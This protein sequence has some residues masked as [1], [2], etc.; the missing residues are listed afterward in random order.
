MIG[1]TLSHYRVLKQLGAG[2]MGVVY[3]ARDTRLERDVAIKMLPKEFA[4]DSE[5]L[6]RFKREAKVL[7][8]LNHSNIGAIYGLEEPKRGVVFLVLEWI[9]GETL[10]ARLR[11]GPLPPGEALAVCAH[12]AGALAA[13]HERGVIHRDLKPANVMLTASGHAK[14]LDFGLARRVAVRTTASTTT[15]VTKPGVAMGTLGYASPEQVRGEEHDG[16]AD[17]FAL[18]CVL[19]ECLT[20]K[21]AFSGGTAADVLA[22]TL[23]QEPDWPALP[24]ETPIKI[25]ELLE[26]CLRKEPQE[27]LRSM[28]DARIEID[29]L[30]GTR[31]LGG[32]TRAATPAVPNN[33]PKQLTNFVGREAEIAECRG[34]LEACRLLTLTGTGGC[35]KTRLSLHVVGELLDQ[36]PDGLW[37][38]DLAPLFDGSRVPQA[39]ASV[40]NV[41]ERSDK[42]LS[43]TLADHLRDRRALLLLDNCE[44]MRQ[45]SAELAQVLL[46][47]CPELKLIATSREALGVPGER[48]YAVPPLSL[49]NRGEELEAAALGSY[50][51]IRLFVD[52]ASLVRSGF[53]LTDSNARAVAEICR[54]LDGIPLAIE[55]AAAR[56]KVLSPA[57][58]Q[59]KLDDRFRLLTGGSAVG[60]PRHQTLEA[61]VRWSYDQLTHDEQRLFRAVSVFSGGW[62]LE[63]AA[64]VIND[65][66]DE[67]AVLDLLT[68]LVD[69]SLVTVEGY[70]GGASRY[71]FLETIRE[72]AVAKLKE[73]GEEGA[74]RGRHL[75]FFLSLAE[76]AGPHLIEEEEEANWLLR[77]ER[78][79]ENLLT[80]LTWCE[81]AED[82]GEKALRLA[83]AIGQFWHTR[84]HVGLG[85]KILGRALE[86]EG[87]AA[88]TVARAKALSL[89]ASLTFTQGDY[90][91]A[92]AL[93]EASFTIYREL[94]D[95]SGIA[96]GLQGRAGEAIM[97]GDLGTARLVLEESLT[98]SREA[99]Y[100][101]GAL[102]GLLGLG[103]VARLG[104]DLHLARRWFEESL[105]LSRKT[106]AKRWIVNNLINLADLSVKLGEP[107]KGRA[108]LVEAFHL[109]QELGARHAATG[110]LES[111]AWVAAACGHPSPAA[112]F[113]GAAEVLRQTMG[114]PLHGPQTDL[115]ERDVVQRLVCSQLGE[116]RFAAGVA[117]GR[118]QS[119]EA[120]IADAL[121]W[122]DQVEPDPGAN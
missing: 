87:A 26:R 116:A 96:R 58:I 61:T 88:G 37:V 8:S 74:L 19:Y 54:R 15:F 55:L 72:Y 106:H 103:V 68:R 122:I 91:R 85:R 27:R 71:G 4:R 62:G 94:G 115:E 65:S 81:R 110:A 50:E 83:G 59:A 119:F 108:R 46:R 89:L 98:I 47:E 79:H 56:A 76:T 67:I 100:E 60:L 105:A 11:R 66:A 20:G 1:R 112:R 17:I 9:D 73:S 7:A 5:R 41:R 45:S 49:P 84:G 114:I 99:G 29:D 102:A 34:L 51:A 36:F 44:H 39:V 42:S 52:R 57:E 93:G 75:D 2:G 64:A 113:F 78:E 97:K 16:R 86:R 18:G 32:R 109:I 70:E 111:L 101:R 92:W 90:E 22:A 28:G 6:A 80:G 35:G 40:I 30:L 24:S 13:A 3:L 31:P 121:Q 104:R 120:A 38:V 53:H 95:I 117:E 23:N 33:L 43:L 48:A 25:R 82:G 12:I 69:Q 14:V 21:R 77:L 10:A 118:A 107:A 63:A